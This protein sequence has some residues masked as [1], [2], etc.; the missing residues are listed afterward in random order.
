MADELF[1]LLGEPPKDETTPTT[2][3]VRVRVRPGPGR[4]AI[5][6]R[7]GDALA[8]RIAPPVADPRSITACQTLLA[9]LFG[10]AVANVVLIAGETA[11]EKR[12]S[13]AD[14]LVSEAS[15]RITQA[16]EDAARGPVGGGRGGRPGR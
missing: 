5:L 15:R 7:Q 10:V 12:F 3:A 4:A 2:I 11:V 14:V 13:V 9:E 1:E 16:V 6:G 8:F